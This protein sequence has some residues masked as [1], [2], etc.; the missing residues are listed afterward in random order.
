MIR[1]LRLGW[2]LCALTVTACGK[3]PSEPSPAAPSTSTLTFQVPAGA[4]HGADSLSYT[5]ATATF[6]AVVRTTCVPNPAIAGSV[7]PDLIAGVRGMDGRQC[8]LWA[9]APVGRSFGVGSYPRAAFSPTTDTAGF[10][11]NCA[12]GGSTCGDNSSAF[13]VGELQSDPVTGIVRRLHITFEQTC[14]GGTPPSTAPFGKGTGEL[15]IID[16]ATGFP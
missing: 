15:W 7:C 4:V 8:I 6:G 12:R 2:F 10:F 3:S 5:A 16:G 1:L 14:L 9:F 13:T 11:I